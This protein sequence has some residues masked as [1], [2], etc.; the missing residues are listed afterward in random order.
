MS[1]TFARQS[2]TIDLQPLLC[3]PLIPDLA[4]LDIRYSQSKHQNHPL[5]LDNLAYDERRAGCAEYDVWCPPTG[6]AIA[7]S[8]SIRAT[9][10]R[11]DTPTQIVDS[12][13]M[14]SL[15][16]DGARLGV[17]STEQAPSEGPSASTEPPEVFSPQ[18]Q[19]DLP[20]PP[21]CVIVFAGEHLVWP[22]SRIQPD[23]DSPE[24]PNAA[25]FRNLKQKTRAAIS[26]ELFEGSIPD[27]TSNGKRGLQV[28]IESAASMDDRKQDRSYT[29]RPTQ[30]WR[31]I[32]GNQGWN[33]PSLFHNFVEDL[34]REFEARMREC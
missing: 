22:S 11:K 34:A 15:H 12:P 14:D 31:R 16:R 6:A 18:L 9:P 1:S 4:I 20:M 30:D 5:L 26:A 33:V 24:F 28:S 27:Y 10:A 8:A 19:E 13:S 3:Q 32:L 29:E 2:D 25:F 17:P 7:P 21:S 23:L